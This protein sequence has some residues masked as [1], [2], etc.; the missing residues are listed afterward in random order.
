MLA[1]LKRQAVFQLHEFEV[2][3]DSIRDCVAE[4]GVV[5]G[6][7]SGM[8]CTHLACSCCGDYWWRTLTS[9]DTSRYDV[10]CG[11]SQAP[12]SP[13]LITPAPYLTSS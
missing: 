1:Q 7:V 5:M 4:V 2:V 6:V 10:D 13:L 3:I 11:L 8:M 9:Q 12:P